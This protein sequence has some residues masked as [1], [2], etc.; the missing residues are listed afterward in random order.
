MDNEV[1]EEDET[2]LRG[3]GKRNEKTRAILIRIALLYLWAKQF[4]YSGTI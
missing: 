3:A 4:R 2:K 1:H